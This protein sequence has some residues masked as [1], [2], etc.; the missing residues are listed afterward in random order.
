MQ[1]EKQDKLQPTYDVKPLDCHSSEGFIV[2]LID[3]LCDVMSFIFCAFA[4]NMFWE[5]TTQMQEFLLI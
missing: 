4:R 3:S 1:F 5:Y 2:C